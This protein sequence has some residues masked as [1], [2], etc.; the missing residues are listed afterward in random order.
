M[1]QIAGGAASLTLA[2]SPKT[3]SFVTKLKVSRSKRVECIG[4]DF[5]LFYFIIQVYWCV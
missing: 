2:N 5:I 4:A 1:Y 3:R